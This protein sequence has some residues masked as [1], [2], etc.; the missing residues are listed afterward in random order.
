M[1]ENE[2]NRELRKKE[3]R[4][5]KELEVKYRKENKVIGCATRKQ[6]VIAKSAK[7]KSYEQ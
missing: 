3:K 7:M 4:K 6:R 1:L 5:L 2:K